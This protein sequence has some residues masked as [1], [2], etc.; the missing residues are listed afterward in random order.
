MN[1]TRFIALDMDG[2]LLP[3]SKVLGERT[4]RALK[5]AKELGYSLCICSGRSFRGVYKYESLKP[6]IDHYICF[7][8][9][10]IVDNRSP[11][12]PV[13]VHKETMP[14]VEL[15]TIIEAVE[16]ENGMMA[17]LCEEKGHCANSRPDIIESVGIWGA[18]PVESDFSGLYDA[19]GR[20]RVFIVL[21]YGDSG[22]IE[23]ISSALPAYVRESFDIIR[24]YL[25]IRDLHHLVI[26]AP[27]INKWN[28]IL[29]VIKPLGI[30]PEE[31]MAFGDWHNDL[32]MIRN[33][34]LGI[35][36]KNGEPDI[37]K[38]ARA[39]TEF[40]NDEEGVA[41]YIESCLIERRG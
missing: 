2:T 40:T 33:A 38:V 36:M 41:R 14:I 29:K 30:S 23:R 13:V 1:S 7:E 37:I 27:R 31:V 22:Q 4:I 11:V 39:V 10:F 17:L 9:G 12:K 24:T 6:I 20:D 25:D 28:G 19:I 21:I 35:A 32:E 3:E 34:G 15:A 26:K 18:V 16:N 5:M 8:G